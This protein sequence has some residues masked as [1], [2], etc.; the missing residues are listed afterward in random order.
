ME[1]SIIA[2]GDAMINPDYFSDFKEIYE[3]TYKNSLLTNL[4]DILHD[5]LNIYMYPNKSISIETS[6][7]YSKFVIKYEKS[8]MDIDEIHKI[9]IS[10][11]EISRMLDTS[12]QFSEA[13]TNLGTYYPYEKFEKFKPAIILA[14]IYYFGREPSK[15]CRNKL[16]KVIYSTNKEYENM[17]TKNFKLSDIISYDYEDSDDE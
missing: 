17:A 8:S 2:N 13:I 14:F 1:D 11:C 5:V 16:K 6:E 9:D 15:T 3:Y 12:S 4:K 7:R 10:I